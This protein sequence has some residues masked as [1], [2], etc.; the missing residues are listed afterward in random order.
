MRDEMKIIRIVSNYYDTK[1]LDE[2]NL[3]SQKRDIVT[4]RQIAMHLI[5]KYTRLSLQQTGKIFNK[6]HSTVLHSKKTI[7]NLALV[8]KKFNKE[9][10][11]LNVI[12]RTQIYI[13]KDLKDLL[14]YDIIL[15]LDKMNVESV[16]KIAKIIIAETPN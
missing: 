2:R 4:P 1:I 8:D 3:K 11:E 16:S 9:L 6:D 12:I 15:E 10:L 5:K 7:T 13:S 14:I